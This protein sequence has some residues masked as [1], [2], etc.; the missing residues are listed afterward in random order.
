MRPVQTVDLGTGRSICQTMLPVSWNEIVLPRQSARV[1]RVYWLSNQ[2]A[3]CTGWFLTNAGASDHWW[4]LNYQ[5]GKILAQG[6]SRS[7]PERGVYFELEPNHVILNALGEVTEDGDDLFLVAGGGK[8]DPPTVA[9][10]ID[11]RTFEATDLGRIDRPANGSFGLVPGGKHFHLGLNIYNRRSLR[12]VAAKD[13]RHD[14]VEI[15]LVTFSA[16]GGRYAAALWR[17]REHK[18]PQHF[19]FVHETLTNRLLAA[20]TPSAAVVHLRLSPD[21]T[22]LAIADNQGTVE[23]R[24]VSADPSAPTESAGE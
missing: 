2:E 9:G 21:G 12:L 15:G 22:R 11:L 19:V 7:I 3:L 14:E 4:R 17:L 8:G 6:I 20:F 18:T 10:R 13:F 5:T 1:R 23:L 16:D 24:S